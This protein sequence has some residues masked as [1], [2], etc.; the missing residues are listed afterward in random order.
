MIFGKDSDSSS[1]DEDDFNNDENGET[2]KQ[3]QLAFDLLPQSKYSSLL[4]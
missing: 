1:S 4:I 3:E 2:L